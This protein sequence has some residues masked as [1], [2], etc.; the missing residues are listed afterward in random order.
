MWCGRVSRQVVRLSYYVEFV[1]FRVPSSG[2]DE[3]FVFFFYVR[4]SFAAGFVGSESLGVGQAS[5]L[6]IPPVPAWFQFG[7]PIR[8]VGC[9][10]ENF[11]TYPH[12]HKVWKR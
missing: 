1:V 7:V 12:S 6:T 8:V 2:G 4:Y 3:L 5:R 9:Y 11:H 10:G